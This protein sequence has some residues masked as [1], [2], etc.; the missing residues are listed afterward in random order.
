MSNLMVSD[1]S[2]VKDVPSN[3]SKRVNHMSFVNSYFHNS[4]IMSSSMLL[5]KA[6]RAME[7]LFSKPHG[8]C[9]AGPWSH[10]QIRSKTFSRLQKP[11]A[12]LACVGSSY[13]K[14]HSYHGS[15]FRPCLVQQLCSLQMMPFF[16]LQ[17]D[18]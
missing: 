13:S 5:R 6:M 17:I 7:F 11:F 18:D 9:D 14:S 1:L 15:I 12:L 2:L 16:I 3:L 8:S 10:P 4:L